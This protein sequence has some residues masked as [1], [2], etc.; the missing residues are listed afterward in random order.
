MYSICI[1][2]P[3]KIIDMPQRFRWQFLLIILSS[4]NI[5]LV[6]KPIGQRNFSGKTRK[7]CSS[8]SL[9]FWIQGSYV[10][11]DLFLSKKQGKYVQL[12]LFLSE[13]QGS[14]V[15]LA[16]F[17]SEK[18]GNYVQLALF[19]QHMVFMFSFIR[20][21]KFWKNSA[22]FLRNFCQK[23]STFGGEICVSGL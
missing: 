3:R 22:N 23:C 2:F 18:Q 14:Y 8:E 19:P 17:L 13:K 21:F 1:S 16:L 11:L 5:V 12:A 10:L 9:P 7:Q 20:L 6:V 15:Q 4:S